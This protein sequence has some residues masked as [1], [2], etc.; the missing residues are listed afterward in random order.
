MPSWEERRKAIVYPT[1]VGGRKR[2]RILTT[3]Q[4]GFCGVESMGW[5]KKLFG[6][7][8]FTLRYWRADLESREQILFPQ[9]SGH[10]GKAGSQRRRNLSCSH[11][12]GKQPDFLWEG[13]KRLYA[14]AQLQGFALWEIPWLGMEVVGKEGKTEMGFL[15]LLNDSSKHYLYCESFCYPI[16][17]DC[18]FLQ[19]NSSCWSDIM[20]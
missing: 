19:K 6:Q 7:M 17:Q 1:Q 10:V 4:N 20:N 8:I 11:P 5:L 13:S 18:E 12:S 15:L 16:S 3:A 2:T 9:F 14:I